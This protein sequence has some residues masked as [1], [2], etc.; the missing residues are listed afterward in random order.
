MAQVGNIIV[1]FQIIEPYASYTNTM[2]HVATLGSYIVA[3]ARGRGIGHAMSRATFAY[4]LEAG[5]TKV[6]ILVRSDNPSAQAFYKRLGFQHCGRLTRQA[7]VDGRFV[8]ELLFELFL[9]PFL[10]L[11]R[12]FLSL[13]SIVYLFFL[14]F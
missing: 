9:G 1:G 12:A 8:D 4:A 10:P 11:L 5:F 3:P 6:V 13:L 7:F 14:Q 2:D